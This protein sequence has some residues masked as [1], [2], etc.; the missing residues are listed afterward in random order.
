M[1]HFAPLR[2]AESVIVASEETLVIAELSIAP[3]KAPLT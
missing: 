3:V 2:L 1:H